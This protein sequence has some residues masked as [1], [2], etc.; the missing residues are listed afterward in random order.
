MK[1]EF[2]SKREYLEWLASVAMRYHNRRRAFLEKVARV[3]PLITVIT[4]G[5]TYTA[6]VGGASALGATIA[7]V[8]AFVGALS[9]T[10]NFGESARKHGDLYRRWALLRGNLRKLNEHDQAS[11]IDL[12]LERA[13]IE[14]D[15]PSQLEALSVI[16][17]N[18]EREFRRNPSHRVFWHQRIFA[19]VFTLPPWSFPERGHEGKTRSNNSVAAK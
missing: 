18:E 3:D 5:A 4:G 19:Q 8:S 9:L 12:E 2:H 16:C 14:A 6:L 15:T 17:E 1:S 13:N 10:C 7:L 11:L